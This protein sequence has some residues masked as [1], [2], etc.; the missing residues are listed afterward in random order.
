MIYCK[1]KSA[2]GAE[3]SEGTVHNRVRALDDCRRIALIEAASQHFLTPPETVRS[4]QKVWDMT[5]KSRRGGSSSTRN[6]WESAPCRT[7]GLTKKPHAET[8]QTR[9]GQKRV[10]A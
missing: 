10:R 1:L 9:P 7:T 6:G 8:I 5:P 4:R 3:R 2:R